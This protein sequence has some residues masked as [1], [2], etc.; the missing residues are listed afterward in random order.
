MSKN[1]LYHA[2]GIRD[3]D[4]SSSQYKE[5]KVIFSIKR[6]P[7]SHKCPKCGSDK[8]LRRGV[9]TRTFRTLPIGSGP[10]LVEATIQQVQCTECGCVRQEK[11][12]FAEPKKSYTHSF[13]RYVIEL[14]KMMTIQDIAL[15][16]GIKLE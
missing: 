4:Y 15:H 12:S 11:L 5:G 13:E 16:L 7:D 10:I 6:H 2:Y 8:V 9:V 14:S 1:L 3:F